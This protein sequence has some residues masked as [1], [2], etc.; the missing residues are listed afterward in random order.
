MVFAV[1][2]I[3][4]ATASFDFEYW[5]NTHIPMALKVWS[6]FGIR[7]CKS[8]R[9]S[10]ALDTS[11]LGGN[12]SLTGQRPYSY[13]AYLIWDSVEDFDK[14][15]NSEEAK[16]IHADSANFTDTLPILLTGDVVYAV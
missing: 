16:P 1:T 4:P 14:A 8:I 7:E 3:Y 13:G 9:Y 5:L 12:L 11:T 10:G 2:I 6:G 15:I